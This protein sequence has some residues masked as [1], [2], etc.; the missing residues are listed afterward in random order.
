VMDNTTTASTNIEPQPR[1]VVL[2]RKEGKG[3]L[4]TGNNFL[5]IGAKNAKALRSARSAARVGCIVHENYHKH[6]TKEYP[7][8]RSTQ[9]G[10]LSNTSSGI[11]LSQ[12]IKLRYVKGFTQAVS[13][14]CRL[15]DLS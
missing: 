5:L 8:D 2:K 15:E 6:S 7:A 14:P 12:V 3:K 13:M 4:A 11:P 10:R 9:H 1:E